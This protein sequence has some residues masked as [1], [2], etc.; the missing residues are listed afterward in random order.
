MIKYKLTKRKNKI[1][2]VVL[3]TSKELTVLINNPVD[4]Q[5]D[6]LLIINNSKIEKESLVL[7]ELK[8]Y[9]IT[10]KFKSICIKNNYQKIEYKN[11]QDLFYYL[12]I[13]EIFCEL[14]LTKEDSIYI[15]RV[16]DIKHN[17]I[18][19]D[20]YTTDFN[21][22]DKAYVLFDDIT[23]IKIFTDYSLTFKEFHK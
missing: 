18:D 2:G 17:S 3:N 20:F 11:F 1:K 16:I 4:Y 22:L 21:L 23:T 12:K 7:D 13:N 6:G 5:I 10:D 14:S 15:G 19:I 9:I 8:D